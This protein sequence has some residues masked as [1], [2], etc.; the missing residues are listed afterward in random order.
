MRRGFREIKIRSWSNLIKQCDNLGKGWILRGHRNSA[1]PLQ[2]SLECSLNNFHINLREAPR[3]EGGLLRRF[4]RQFHHFCVSSPEEQ[5]IMEWL[6]LMQ[7]YGGPTRLLDWTHSFFAALYFAVEYATGKCA[8]WALDVNWVN[9]RIKEKYPDIWELVGDD[10]KRPCEGID[11]NA[12]NFE[13]FKT[14][15]MGKKPFVITMN[16]LRLNERLAIQQGTF[17]CPG[18]ITR[19]FETNLKGLL[20]PS[21]SGLCFL[22]I[23][24]DLR[25]WLCYGNSPAKS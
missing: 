17:L 18:D 23:F 9:R 14:A 5:D 24:P 16:S 6:A 1:W 10:K 19:P 8:V 15:F 7:H 2:T 11:P 3:L 25:L 13:T 4:Q 22:T 21:G 12:R 20:K